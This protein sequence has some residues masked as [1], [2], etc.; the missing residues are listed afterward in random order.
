MGGCKINVTSCVLSIKVAIYA[1][2]IFFGDTSKWSTL[3][4]EPKKRTCSSFGNCVISLYEFLFTLIGMS[5][6][7]LISKRLS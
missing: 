5:Y 6:L 2:R 4:V 3:P 1:N 7:S